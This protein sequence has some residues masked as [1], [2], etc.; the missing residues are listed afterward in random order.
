VRKPLL[1][2]RLDNRGE[3]L[4]PQ[5]GA[6]PNRGAAPTAIRGE[7]PLPQPSRPVVQGGAWPANRAKLF[8][9]FVSTLL[10]R[11]QTCQ[12]PAVSRFQPGDKQAGIDEGILPVVR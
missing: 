1:Q 5:G 11:E 7:A 9:G 12:H 2:R 4:L 8:D 3:A 10:N 6:A